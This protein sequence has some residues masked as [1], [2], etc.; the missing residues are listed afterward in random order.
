M[1]ASS[2]GDT[3]SKAFYYVCLKQMDLEKIV[4]WRGDEVT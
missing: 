3:L 1:L 4:K 2:E